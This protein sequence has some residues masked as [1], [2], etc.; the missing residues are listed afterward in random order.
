LRFWTMG[1]AWVSCSGTTIVFNSCFL[2][3]KISNLWHF[4]LVSWKNMTRSFRNRCNDYTATFAC[5]T[6][7]RCATVM[8]A[9]GIWVQGK[10]GIDGR[11]PH[12][13]T[14]GSNILPQCVHRIRILPISAETS[15]TNT[16]Y[17]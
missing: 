5:S 10:L 1:A 4:A 13:Q 3:K 11:L 14:V 16:F 2:L 9:H 7:L 12:T 6:Q 8:L 17:I 15:E